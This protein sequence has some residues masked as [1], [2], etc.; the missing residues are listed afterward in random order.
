V[1][2]NKSL[3][4][5]KRIWFGWQ[6]EFFSMALAGGGI[7]WQKEFFSMALAGWWHS[8]VKG[9]S[10]NG[11]YNSRNP[12]ARALEW[13]RFR[14]ILAMAKLKGNESI[15]DFGCG[16]QALKEV[17][18]KGCKYVGYDIV[19]EYS[20]TKDYTRLKGVDVVFSLSVFEHLSPED[21]DSNLKAFKK[22]GV[23]RLVVELPREDS[24]VN[25]FGSWLFGL[26]FD[27]TVNHKLGWREAIK[28]IDR[29][30]SCIDF[31]NRAFISWVSTWG[32]RA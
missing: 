9:I 15:L 7:V 1:K 18:P 8:L 24:S 6:K 20:D 11:F 13:G 12:V 25:R 3:R 21:L 30:F 31:K 5:T 17:L 23:K 32:A 10:F 2:V 28:I 19:S 22:M 14:K 29:H 27:H 26:E 4:N 16:V